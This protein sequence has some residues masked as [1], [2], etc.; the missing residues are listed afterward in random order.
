MRQPAWI[1]AD[2]ATRCTRL[3]KC[4]LAQ[5]AGGSTLM[6]T[7]VLVAMY[8]V[9][10][11]SYERLSAATTSTDFWDLQQAA[12]WA[13]SSPECPLASTWM[14]SV[15]AVKEPSKYLHVRPTSERAPWS[16]PVHSSCHELAAAPIGSSSRLSAPVCPARV[17][18]RGH[19]QTV[20]KSWISLLKGT[21]L[22]LLEA[23]PAGLLCSR[24]GS[25][26]WCSADTARPSAAS[27]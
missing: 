16:L 17:D 24:V 10:K 21:W 1:R 23:V 12:A 26:L 18:L 27:G 4:G 5:N 9:T 19:L 8:L 6:R 7:G 2:W 13:L 22:S 11:L 25:T 20:G 15:R 3:R 14:Y